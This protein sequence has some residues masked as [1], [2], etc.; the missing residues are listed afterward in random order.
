MDIQLGIKYKYAHDQPLAG[1]S[2]ITLKIYDK[3]FQKY[4]IKDLLI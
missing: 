2:N 3:H 1:S 4:L